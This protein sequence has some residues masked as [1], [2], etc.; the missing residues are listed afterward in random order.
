MTSNY[1]TSLVWRRFFTCLK[2]RPQYQKP[3]Q[4]SYTNFF[5]SLTV[6]WIMAM[7]LCDWSF[8]LCTSVALLNI[9]L[10]LLL[11]Q[12]IAARGNLSG[13]GGS[14][15]SESHGPYACLEKQI[16]YYA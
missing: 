4:A 8:S 10:M 7:A 14:Q 6:W 12:V 16:D 1:L 11:K 2:S 15:Y 3:L 5:S 13:S 9:K